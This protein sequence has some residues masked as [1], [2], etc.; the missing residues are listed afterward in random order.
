MKVRWHDDVRVDAKSFILVAEVE[1]LGND[2]ARRL[3]DEN[4]EPID[5]GKRDDTRRV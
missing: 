1:A 5:D 4:R 2:L 3:G